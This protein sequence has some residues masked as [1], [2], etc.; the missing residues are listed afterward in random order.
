M[1]LTITTT[2][3]PATD[4]GFLLGKNPERCQSFD[5]NFGK[6]HVFYPEASAERCTA[7]L[8]L[9]VD[10]VGLVRRPK[11][12]DF[13]LAE[14]TNDRPYVASS[15]L[16]VAIGRVLRA[17]LSGRSRERQ[18][19]ADAA[20]PLEL[21]LSALPARGGERLLRGLFEPLGYDLELERLALAD[22]LPDWGA[23]PYYRLTLRGELRVADALRHLTVLIPV[24]DDD[25]HYWVGSDEVDKLLDR[26]AGW[27]EDHPLREVIA[28]RYLKHQRSLTRDALSRL[29]DDGDDDP[30]ASDDAAARPEEAAEAP[31]SLDEARRQAVLAA[32]RRVGAVRV[33]D[34][35]CGEGKL[36][37]ALLRDKG[38]KQAGAGAPAQ[39]AGMDVSIRAL[40]RAHRRLRLDEASEAARA[41][42]QLFQGSLTY[43]DERLAGF[44]AACA[45]EVVEHLDPSRLG[46]F[47]TT[48]FAYARPRAVIV[49]TPNR[50]HNVR[51]AN[52]LQNGLRHGDHRFEWT[53]AEFA[54]WAEAIG[55][56]RGYH[57]EFAGVGDDDPEVG[58]P[59]VMAVFIRD[60]GEAGR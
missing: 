40:E 3:A 34:V 51:F 2:R 36:L 52:L 42:V 28:A 13:A 56:R 23:S 48:L 4:L 21:T 14:Y 27:L 12:D 53:R 43:R 15:L 54:A 7:A 55:E 58:P 38:L 37:R 29:S 18:D 57:V 32:L 41:R 20:L 10:P 59:T 16:S 5:L 30:E 45:I 11:G 35:G 8:V 17:G 60:E 1:L 33:I 46:A 39:F 26:G 19:L 49:T 44:D 6:A 9:D 50:E 22:D 25:K 31:L 24:L 47:E